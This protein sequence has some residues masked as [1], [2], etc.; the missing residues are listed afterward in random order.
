MQLVDDI[1]LLG[2]QAGAGP[3]ALQNL[4]RLDSS[5]G[6]FWPFVIQT[7]QIFATY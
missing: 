3:S 2:G 5:R 1:I 7:I 4:D 6:K